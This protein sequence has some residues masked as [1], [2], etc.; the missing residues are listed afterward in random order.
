MVSASDYSQKLS[1]SRVKMFNESFSRSIKINECNSSE[2]NKSIKDR[3]KDDYSN[4]NL[5]KLI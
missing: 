4:K 5:F 2:R 1:I 3:I